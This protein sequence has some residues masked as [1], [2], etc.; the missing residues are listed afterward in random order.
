MAAGAAEH[1]LGLVHGEHR[2]GVARGRRRA[3]ITAYRAPAADLRRSHR[4]GRLHKRREVA[5]LAFDAVIRHPRAKE[6]VPVLPSQHPQL[7]QPA[8]VKERVGAQPPKVHLDH[9]VGAA[10]D[11][12]GL[13]PGRLHLER[14][15]K[16]T[17]KQ[18]VHI[19]DFPQPERNRP[20]PYLVHQSAIPWCDGDLRQVAAEVGGGV[21][22]RPSGLGDTGQPTV[23][24]KSA[25][26]RTGTRTL[27]RIHSGGQPLEIGTVCP[28]RATSRPRFHTIDG[29]N[30]RTSGNATYPGAG[31]PRSRR[32]AIGPC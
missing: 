32:A 18:H 20:E 6:Q 17:G 25:A 9:K 10:R 3:E 26:E 24:R 29:R 4:A 14:L 22:V 8:H 15:L 2:E 31:A 16:R 30:S 27:P 23:T 13:R 5:E 7:G 12:H 28:W 11:R 1:D 21:P 19:R